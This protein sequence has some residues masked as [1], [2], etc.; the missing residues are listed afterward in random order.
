MK[1]GGCLD[2]IGFDLVGVD[3]ATRKS[4][5]LLP[6]LQGGQKEETEKKKAGLGF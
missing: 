1:E 4:V 3:R 5:N 2:W 6:L